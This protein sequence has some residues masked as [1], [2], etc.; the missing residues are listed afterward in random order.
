MTR[1][2]LLNLA[3]RIERAEGPDRVFEA[4]IYATIHPEE[5]ENAA[6][7]KHYASHPPV[8]RADLIY[9]K[10]VGVPHYT[11]SLDAAMQLVPEG[12]SWNLVSVGRSEPPV[13]SVYL[14]DDT[15]HVFRGN[16]ATPALALTAAALRALAA[17]QQERGS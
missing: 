5:F 4:A 3:D 10:S 2:D 15:F 11:S 8:N 6:E 14:P 13:A 12:A 16:A 17:S 1:T 7:A 9:F